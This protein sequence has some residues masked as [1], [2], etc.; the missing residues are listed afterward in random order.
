MLKA[1]VPDELLELARIVDP[2]AR[3]CISTVSRVD[4]VLAQ[5]PGHP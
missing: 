4:E 2:A 5:R 3:E 1:S